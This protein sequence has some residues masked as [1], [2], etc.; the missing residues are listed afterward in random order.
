MTDFSKFGHSKGLKLT[1]LVPFSA[2]VLT[3]NLGPIR[4]TLGGVTGGGGFIR[5]KF[6]FPHCSTGVLH[7]PDG[8]GITDSVGPKSTGF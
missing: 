3:T 4:I 8:M 6:T 5:G 1:I 2:E 7:L